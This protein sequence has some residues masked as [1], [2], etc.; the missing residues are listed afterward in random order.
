MKKVILAAAFIV[1]S[2]VGYGAAG[3][4]LTISDIKTGLVEGDSKKVSTNV[5]FTTLRKN[6]KDQFSAAMSK[7]TTPGSKVDSLEGM[8]NSMMSKMIDGMLDKLVTPEGL[9]T[10][11]EGKKKLLSKDDAQQVK[12]DDLFKDATFTYDS[13]SKFSIRVTNEKGQEARFI[14]KHDGLSW[15]LVNIEIPIATS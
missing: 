2:L 14:L 8:A 7:N 4:Y 15:R 5:D 10:M 11:M 1:T 3:P 13:I 6:L 12:K 9:I